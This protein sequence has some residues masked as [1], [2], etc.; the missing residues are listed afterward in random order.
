M[1]DCEWVRQGSRGRAKGHAGAVKGAQQTYTP[2]ATVLPYARVL[3]FNAVASAIDA[4]EHA[5]HA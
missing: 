4:K 3:N 2:A 5:M 1:K